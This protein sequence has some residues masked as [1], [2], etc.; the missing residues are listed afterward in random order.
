MSEA[1]N[2]AKTPTAALDELFATVN[3]SDAPGLVVGVAQH[4]KPV[5]RRGF[6]LASL[7]LGVANTPWTRMRIGSTSKHF[8]CLAVLLLAE[9]GKLEVDASVS[10]YL[11]E[12]PGVQGEPT[13]RQLMNHTGGQRCYLDLGF[14]SDAMAIKPKGVA[15]ATQMRQGDVNFVP[16]EKAL[17]NNGGY[18]LLSFVIERVAGVPFEQFLDERIFKPLGMVDT[19]SVQSD[20][21][22]HRNM[23]TMHV[24]Q[25][26][27]GWRR[28]IFPTE[29][30]RGEG[31][32]V[33][34]IDDMLRWLTH[35]RGPHAVGSEDSWAQMT[36]PVTLKN[37][38]SVPYALGLM[39]HDYRG[40]RVIHHPGGVIGG[41]S[42]MLT[43]PEHE[44]DIIIM[45]NGALVSSIDLANKV[46]DVMLG[47]AALGAAVEYPSS[48]RFKGVLGKRYYCSANGFLAG[49]GDAGGKLGICLVNSP[50]LPL[51]DEGATLRLGFEDISA[52]PFI[53]RTSDIADRADAPTTLE[54]SES[55]NVMHLELL[56]DAAPADALTPTPGRYHSADLDA[57]AEILRDEGGYKLRI[58]GRYAVNEFAMQA[59]SADVAGIAHAMHPQ[60]SAA[61]SIERRDGIVA[62]FR[63]DS[64]RTRG[65]RFKR[66]SA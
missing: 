18:Q 48:D 11:P 28:G 63:I 27:G 24:P 16:G 33:S 1:A 52:G 35:L 53:V 7:E 13:L 54:L 25:L 59:L 32:I 57:D 47:D 31:A 22:I 45:T 51:R 58:F 17:Y 61:L 39:V 4:S 29:E 12:L 3:R 66:V 64:G 14:L 44:L 65:L 9:E 56:P 50:P 37:G 20:F 36:T 2:P 38:S 55:G 23:A 19:K 26:D 40:V 15:F 5:Y 6:G 30:V 42:Q 43:V 21:E 46:I 62:G 10:R 49:F 60:L 34:S 8:T 41:S